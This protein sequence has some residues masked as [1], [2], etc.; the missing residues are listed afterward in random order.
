M[1]ESKTGLYEYEGK[2][3]LIIVYNYSL[4]TSSA[5]GTGYSSYWVW[6][7]YMWD[8]DPTK[9]IETGTIE[10][11]E[12]EGYYSLG[13]SL[14]SVVSK[15]YY[16][17]LKVGI[18]VMM[19]VLVYIGIRILISSVAADK[20][21][22]KQM[23]MDWI[24]GFVLLFT[25]HYIMVFA[26]TLND[27]LIELVESIGY[28]NYT[29][30]LQFNST[31][32]ASKIK[33]L[34]SGLDEAAIEV[35]TIDETLSENA[36]ESSE[37]VNV[38]LENLK[39]GSLD[40]IKITSGEYVY[41]AFVTDMMGAVRM[42][43]DYYQDESDSFI[44][45]SIMFMVLVLLTF[46]YVIMYFKRVMYMAFFTIIAPLVAVTYP[47][48]K[49]ND[50][51]AQGFDMW[52]KE[53]M[54]NLLL[55][56]MHLLLY[57]ILIGSAIEIAT[58]NLVWCL[59]VMMFMT[60]GEEILRRL[61]NFGKAQTPGGLKGAVAAGA[62]MTGMQRLFGHQPKGSKNGNDN[63]NG[64][65]GNDD[66]DDDTGSG[67]NSSFNWNRFG[68]GAGSG[69][70]N[71]GGLGNNGGSSSSGGSRISRLAS[72]YGSKAKKQA[73]KGVKKM[74]KAVLKTAGGLTLGAAGGLVGVAAGVASG[75]MSKVATFGA[76]GAAAGGKFGAK[77][78]A[79]AGDAL[80]PD[81]LRKNNRDLRMAWQ[82]NAEFQKNE[83]E[84]RIK[85]MAQNEDNIR[86]AQMK[87]KDENGNIT[88]MS[89]KEAQDYLKTLGEYYDMNEGVTTDASTMIKMENYAKSLGLNDMNEA[90]YQAIAA[91]KLA[92]SVQGKKKGD[93]LEQIANITGLDP[94]KNQQEI[95]AL[96]QNTL[97]YIRFSK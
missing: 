77:A 82:G 41:Y 83:A 25:M 93:A 43:V 84:R 87:A 33:K 64:G 73:I 10:T 35:I 44:G 76:A 38:Y 50:G 91:E 11:V 39:N 34:E 63:G 2:Y 40:V 9:S 90:R 23:L 68:N 94:V 17:L 81:N 27:Y 32:D 65:S 61:F 16:I 74:P 88:S 96:R 49:A 59:V 18:V 53:Y 62:V 31:N 26:N 55:Q 54:F 69:S 97:D 46:V 21:K 28:R 78:G 42:N 1:L 86:M 52:F 70:G 71:G 22:Y 37:E 30:I 79:N 72:M 5:N 6:A 36:I 89:Y 29:V 75:D 80:N 13:Y 19:S 56:P 20:A 4:T 3:Y 92:N 66:S 24:I 95:D 7:M 60:E 12:N 67:I 47:L 45:Y 58:E 51:S 8:E 48:D 15:W 14:S 57:T 85:Q